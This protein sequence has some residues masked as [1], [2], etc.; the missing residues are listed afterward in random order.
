V[1]E[2]IEQINDSTVQSR[3]SADQPIPHRREE[4][5]ATEASH[6]ARARWGTIAAIAAV[7]FISSGV[8]TAIP[9]PNEP[10]YLCKARHFA[11]PTWCA[12]D[13]FLSSSNPHYWFY[14]LTGPLT[15]WMKFHWV[16]LIGRCVS[17]LTV[18]WGWQRLGTALGLSGR[19]SLAAASLWLLMASIGSLSGEWIIGG[20]ESKV[21]AWGLAFAAVADWI[22]C[23]RKQNFR[24]TITSALLCGLSVSIHPVVGGWTA[25]VLGISELI[26][27]IRPTEHDRTRRIQ[28]W[29]IF[30]I[31][32]MLS[33]LPGL[34]PLKDLFLEPSLSVTDKQY[35]GYIQVFW[36][37]KHH[38][39]PSTFSAQS[40]VHT[41]VLLFLIT[42]CLRLRSRSASASH[43]AAATTGTDSDVVR[44]VVSSILLA[45]AGFLIGWHSIPA[46]RMTD[47][48]WRAALLKF[49]PFR[50]IDGFL[51][52][53]TSMM[54]VSMWSLVRRRVSAG[55]SMPA[56]SGNTPLYQ[57]PIW[58]TVILCLS[59]PAVAWNQRNDVPSG[60]TQEQFDDWLN[61]C[62]WIRNHTDSE[63]LVYTPRESFNFKWYA[64]RAEYIT[65]KDCP[66]DPRGILEWNRRLWYLHD[67]TLK[68]SR[69]N[70]FSNLEVRRLHDE[71]GINL[72]VTRILGPFET[73]PVFSGRHWK[74]YRID[75]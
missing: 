46:E 48:Q 19:S 20:Y 22:R 61:V 9:G 53:L 45:A 37:L 36:R 43:T 30:T 18:A 7:F 59:V 34:L 38:L 44:I 63:A 68:S 67:W 75:K 3:A 66:Q 47:W 11:D 26:G 58:L 25:V 27:V 2:S 65:Y 56:E 5:A 29:A 1:N 14:F 21:P 70:R 40:W 35:A 6:S 31:V 72:I 23:R 62:Q 12:G 69:D 49:Y 17:L 57:V 32:L 33:S 4:T 42:A 74:V 24:A 60:Y 39:D 52:V 71:T 28:R 54:I 41:G 73:E 8:G 51:P 15:L 13:F 50:A 16:A 64:Q 10:H 55:S